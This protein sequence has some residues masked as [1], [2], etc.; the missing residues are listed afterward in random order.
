[1]TKRTDADQGGNFWEGGHMLVNGVFDKTNDYVFDIYM[2]GK[3]ADAFIYNLPYDENL[4]CC[5]EY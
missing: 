5:M 1:M 4:G 2:G 3:I